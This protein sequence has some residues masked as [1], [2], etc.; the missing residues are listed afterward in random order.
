MRI[1]S[2]LTLLALL[3]L[4]ASAHHGRGA[5]QAAVTLVLPAANNVSAN[6]QNAGLQ[7][8]GGIPT[9]STQC[10]STLTPSGG[11][12]LSQIQAALNAC[13]PGDYVLLGSGTFNILMSEVIVLGTSITLR[14][15]GSCN[16][17]STPYC[18]SVINVSNG[19]LPWTGGKCGTDT[20][21]EVAC[22]SNAAINVQPAAAANQF[23]FGWA[24]SLGHCGLLSSA[25]ACGTPVD[26]DAVQGQS[27]IQV[28]STTGFSV[29]QWVL[30]DEASGALYQNDPVGPNL[31]GQVW[32]AP[33]WLSNSPSPATGRV[34]WDKYGNNTGD[35]GA[36][37]YPY[38]NPHVIQSLFD[39][40]TSEIHLVT[41]VGAGPCPGT[42]CTLTFD[43]PITV[44]FRQSGMTTFTGSISGTTLTTS[45]DNCTLS[46]AQIVA[47][48]TDTIKDG[49]YVTAVNSCTG[50]AGNYTVSISQSVSSETVIGGAHQA[51]VYFPTK[52]SGSALAFLSQAGVE[53]LTIQRPT[54]GGVNF[55]FCAYCWT[56]NVEVIG[57]SGGGTNYNYSVRDQMDTT[58]VNNCGDSVNNGAEYPVGIQ[59]A[60]TEIYVVNSITTGCGKGMVGKTGAAAV[61]AYSYFDHTMYDSFSGIGDYWMDMGANGSHF[62]GTHH[63]LFEGNWADNLDND[64]THGNA[65]YHVYFRNW[66]TALRSS[67]TDPSI[68]ATVNDATDTA[69][70]CGTTGAGS[71]SNNA[72]GPLRAAGPMLHTY[73]L[74]YVG[75][76]MGTSGVTTS[77]NGWTYTGDYSTNKHIWQPGWNADANNPTKSDTN[78]NGGTGTYLFRHGNYDYVNGS[79]VDWQAGYTQSL[80]NSLYLA[81]APAFFSAGASCTYTWPWVASTASPPI[82]SNSCSGSGLPAKARWDAGTPFVQP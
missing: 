14:G 16:N 18:A 53:N 49:T 44:S 34:Q 17:A 26:A 77:G 57:W 19:L 21:H 4:F 28:H 41:A 78:L 81:S 62:S 60:S 13:T 2:L 55:Q 6:W 31:R 3:P 74:A 5:A 10:G 67:F 9:R 8:I 71:C 70:A 82:K 24:G 15:T 59:D 65:I 80:P 64:D 61:I 46:V 79:I 66:G 48:A 56:K 63:Y 47:D 39:R 69:K 1:R 38:N 32:A 29:G 50:G 33:D 27:T 25:I 76:V 23:D 37:D 45:G 54:N 40:A 58:L 35:M 68:P 20:S 7:P 22:S 75:N 73:W 43:D 36:G 52:Q 72:P 30:I 11:D 51:H 42:S 12:D